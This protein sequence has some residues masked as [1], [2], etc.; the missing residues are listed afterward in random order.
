VVVVGL[1]AVAGVA[2]VVL[3][4]QSA[5]SSN[6]GISAGLGSTT[7]GDIVNGPIIINASQYSFYQFGIP[8]GAQGI[9]VHAQWSSGSAIGV[10]IMNAT[11]LVGWQ[12]GQGLRT[13]YDSGRAL[14]GDANVQVPPDDLYYLVFDNSRSPTASNA[15]VTSG[16]SY[17]CNLCSID[18]PIQQPSSSSA[19]CVAVNGSEVCSVA[20]SNRGTEATSPTGTCIESWSPDEGPV[21]TWG[22]PHLGVFTPRTPISPSSSLLGRCTVAGFSVPLGLAITVQIPMTDGTNLDLYG[23]SGLRTVVAT[24]TATETLTTQASQATTTFVVPAT[25]CSLVAGSAVTTTIIVGPQLPASTIT[26]TTTVTTT[27]TIYSQTVTVT[28]CMYNPPTASGVTTIVTR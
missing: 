7:T 26:T 27:S 16:I 2:Y 17:L 12:G 24:A 3:Y 9:K 6:T 23:P 25:N 10:Y 20:L 18:E 13:F 21:L 5:N 28:S 22:A 19:S 11:D 1:A 8:Y 15:Q 14:Q 4:N